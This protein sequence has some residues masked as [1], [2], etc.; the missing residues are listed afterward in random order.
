MVIGTIVGI[1]AGHFRGI[2]GGRLNRLAEWFLVIP[3]L[4]LAIVLATVFPPRCSEDHRSDHRDRRGLVARDGAVGTRPHAGAAWPARR[5]A[6]PARAF[7]RLHLPSP[8]P[9]RG[10]GVRLVDIH[11]RE[12]G[13]SRRAACVHVPEGL[14]QRSVVE[15]APTPKTWLGS[16]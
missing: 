4:P 14:T 15:A 12:A 2:F 10:R 16:W 11:L 3:F 6:R 8:V 13:P 5:P 9:G 1:G 7:D